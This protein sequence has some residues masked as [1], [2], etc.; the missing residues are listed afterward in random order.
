MRNSPI[1]SCVRPHV[2]RLAKAGFTYE[3]LVGVKLMNMYLRQLA[4]TETLK[5]KSFLS[6]GFN[7]ICGAVCLGAPVY[8]SRL[9]D[10][11]LCSIGALLSYGALVTRHI[12]VYKEEKK[13]DA[14]RK[15]FKKI[16]FESEEE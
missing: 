4:E 9:D 2:E 11:V 12:K 8:T 15:C 3:E 7:H 13:L 16:E 10:L 6:N 5:N 14:L 1:S